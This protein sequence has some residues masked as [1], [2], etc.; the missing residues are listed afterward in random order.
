MI[1][2]H[3][4]VIFYALRIITSNAGMDYFMDIMDHEPLGLFIHRRD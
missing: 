2:M 4:V 1:I 3:F